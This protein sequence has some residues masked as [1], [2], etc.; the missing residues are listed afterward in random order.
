[1]VRRYLFGD[2][3]TSAKKIWP[4]EPDYSVSEE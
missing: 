4:Q 1:L 2:H 3:S